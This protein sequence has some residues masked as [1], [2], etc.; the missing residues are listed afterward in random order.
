MLAAAVGLS[1]CSAAPSDPASSPTETASAPKPAQ[2]LLLFTSLPIFW[3]EGSLSDMLSDNA[4]RHWAR[5]ALE[6]RWRLVPVDSLTALRNG[7]DAPVLL[8][9]QPRALSGGENVTLDNFV[10]GGGRVVMIVDPMLD[11]H[12]AYG[13]G[14]KRR[15]EAVSMLSPILARWGLRLVEDE[16][17]AYEAQWGGRSVPVADGG[18]FELTDTGFESTC[19]LV[20]DGLAAWCRV[21]NGKVVL[22]ADATFLADGAKAGGDGDRLLLD[23]VDEAQAPIPAEPARDRTVR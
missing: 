15:P 20:G 12:S 21:G 5:K 8:M 23:L 3:S 16:R 9:A 2:D 19:R 14:D 4:E 1:A 6:A 11:A 18:L 7:A 10:R 22:M 17:P 13:F